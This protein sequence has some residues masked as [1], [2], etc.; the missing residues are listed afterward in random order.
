MNL[1][2]NAN[3]FTS[4]GQI[5]INLDWEPDLNT[6]PQEDQML[7]KIIVNCLKK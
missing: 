5:Q 4:N 7:E 2:G 1:L 3:K 6:I